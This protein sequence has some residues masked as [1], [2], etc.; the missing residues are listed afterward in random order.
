MN[1]FQKKHKAK[2]QRKYPKLTDSKKTQIDVN[3]FFF[4]I[5][6]GENPQLPFLNLKI[7]IQTIKKSKIN[8][9]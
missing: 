3:L 4:E 5:K 8:P 2:Q 7:T 1:F 9:H 6:L